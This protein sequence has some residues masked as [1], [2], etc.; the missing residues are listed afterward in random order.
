METAENKEKKPSIPG[1][2]LN[3]VDFWCFVFFKFSLWCC[4]Y[5]YYV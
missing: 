5:N 2:L 3:F 4:W 1:V